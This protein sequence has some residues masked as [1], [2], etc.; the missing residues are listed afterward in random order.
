MNRLNEKIKC[1]PSSIELIKNIEDLKRMAHI[2]S[3]F[4]LT[5]E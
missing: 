3:F 2:F 4:K 5:R 1:H